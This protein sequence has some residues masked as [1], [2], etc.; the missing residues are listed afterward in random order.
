M[1]RTLGLALAALVL[2]PVPAGAGTTRPPLGL[3]ATPARVA[4]AGSDQTA[5]HVTNPGATPVVVDVARAGFSLD[6]RG[7][8][9]VVSGGGQ[10]AASTWLSVRPGRFVL[11]PAASRS[12]TVASRLPRGIQP[13]D[14]DALVLLTT[15][16]RR[17]GGVAVRMRIGVVVV[18]R[19]PGRVVRRLAVRGLRVRRAAGARVLELLVVNRGNVTEPLDRGRV[20]IVV[21]GRSGPVRVWPEPRDLRPRTRG[22]VQAPYR[23][24]L[25]GWVTAHVELALQP[26]APPLRRAFR[27]KL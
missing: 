14:H 27:I 8:P 10:R 3:T 13:G 21:R 26:G 18:V 22:L 1:S 19:A 23:G 20:R 12:V 11:P 7:R 16:P 17:S 4:L 5:L 25:R 6:L 24:R 9:R 15:R 2:V